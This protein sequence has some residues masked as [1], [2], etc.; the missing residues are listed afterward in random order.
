LEAIV[1]L[2]SHRGRTVPALVLILLLA[3]AGCGS[4]SSSSSSTSGSTPS[5][6]ASGADPAI[7]AMV[8]SAIASKGS[9]TVATDASYAPNE[10]FASDGKTIIGMDVDLG[11]A[12]G[13]VMGVQWNFV[14][15]GFD[16]IIPGLASGKYDIGMSS[17]G[18]TKEREQTVDFVTY[19]KAGTAIYIK[20]G[21][22]QLPNL[23]AMCGHSIGV[24]KG[25]TQL[26]DLTAQNT[27]CKNAGKP[28]I[29]IQ[30]FPDQNGAN[31][32]LAAGRVDAAMA[33]T[34]VAD[35]AVAQSNGQ[36]AL[37]GSS[38]G[39]VPYGIAVPKGTGMTK[40]I[41]AA[42]KK[43]IANG[44]YLKILKKWGVQSIAIDNPVINGAVS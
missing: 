11:H 17:F 25:T 29:D 36:F 38:Y 4:S 40:P 6:A 2:T 16:G 39:V 10:F 28:E 34:P 21:G 35:Y 30:A 12:L 7:A 5:S 44:I 9:V 33:D 13:K 26:A 37:S 8:P 32:A 20:A 19:A 43:V 3:L 27:K 1:V 14:E 41:E 42:L 31:T 15:A 24:E 18:D 23:A 22:T